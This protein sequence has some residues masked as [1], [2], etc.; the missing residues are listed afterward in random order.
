MR[1]RFWIPPLLRNISN[2]LFVLMLLYTIALSLFTY[3]IYSR[4]I[5]EDTYQSFVED[6]LLADGATEAF[7]SEVSRLSAH[8]ATNEPVFIPA[9]FQSPANTIANYNVTTRMQNVLLSYEYLD[10]IAVY[11][12]GNDQLVS[13]AEIGERSGEEIKAQVLARYKNG[14]STT[15]F[16]HT[17]NPREKYS[18]SAP[19]DVLTFA[20]YSNLSGPE[21]VG[22]VLMGIKAGYLREL[23][24]Q[25]DS[26]RY[27]PFFLMDEEGRFLSGPEK[28]VSS[29]REQELW[30]KVR[31]AEKESGYFLEK[32]QG[33]KF[34]VSYSKNRRLGYSLFQAVPYDDIFHLL[35]KMRGKAVSL[36][37]L[38]FGIGAAI[39]YLLA[40]WFLSPLYALLR[41][42]NYHL[43]RKNAKPLSEVAFLDHEMV[44]LSHDAEKSQVLM[45]RMA[46]YDLLL[47][48]SLSDNITEAVLSGLSRFPFYLVVLLSVDRQAAKK[49]VSMEEDSVL[50]YAICNIAAEILE[51]DCGPADTILVNSAD[52]AVVVS[53]SD[54][55]SPKLLR[56]AL[57]EIGRLIAEYYQAGVLAT[58]SSVVSGI[59]C[60]SDAYSEALFLME[61]NFLA[62][63]SV[64]LSGDPLSE[65]QHKPFPLTLEEELFS[66]ISTLQEEKI[67]KSLSA[68]FCYISA[69][70]YEYAMTY[71]SRLVIDLFYYSL[72]TLSPAAS[73]PVH[74]LLPEIHRSRSLSQAKALLE[75]MCLETAERCA[76]KKPQYSQ[77]IRQAM[78]LT[79]QNF[80]RVDFSINSVADALNITSSYFNRVFKREYGVS[81]GEYLN[82]MR[83]KQA[84]ELL[85]TTGLST[86]DICA[87]SGF[88]NLS[89]FYT[90][91][92][93]NYGITPMEFRG[94]RERKK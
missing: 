57:E 93:K 44:R 88:S 4:Q 27:A 15:S 28:G 89:Y 1:R 18:P 39:S 40:Y 79:E 24:T 91:F 87:R 12:Q 63:K 17:L 5:T 55:Q 56:E 34:V 11:N 38:F 51:R 72:E 45:R 49:A 29:H 54:G 80:T 92:K 78:E 69:T 37:F 30:E 70:N 47:N 20:A 41:K 52:V 9:M 68:F 58:A 23:Y 35:A 75:R 62:E 46:C 60:L 90:L 48:Q 85:H 84:K 82:A 14:V 2:A 26:A 25:I 77:A 71:I 61:E 59:Y 22:A 42:Y 86:S 10:Y 3:A 66:A 67:Q 81:Y 53:L 19:R 50:R 74:N 33:K 36:T 16:F 32:L 94:S 13:T 6:A 31:Q 73:I 64:L 8:L 21:K 76:P 43:P 7:F 65:H 83:L